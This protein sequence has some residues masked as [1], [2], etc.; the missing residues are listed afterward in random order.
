MNRHF[1][2]GGGG[3]QTDKA[4]ILIL[5]G[6]FAAMLFSAIAFLSIYS[7]S[8]TAANNSKTQI[9]EKEADIK[10]VDVLV[11]IQNIEAGQLLESTMFRLET[12][13]VIGLSP[14]VVKDFEEL[15]GMFSRS[16]IV[17]DQPLVRD[18]ITNVRPTN[19]LTVKIP[20]GYRAVT[21]SVDAKSSV[22]GWARP[23]ARVDLMWASR[24][25]GKPGMTL[26]VQNAQILSAERMI[27]ANVKAGTPLPST[28]T[29]LVTAEDA[30]K[31]QLAQTTGSLSLN[32]RGDGDGGKGASTGSINIDA[33]LGTDNRPAGR[34]PN[35]V[36]VKMRNRKGEIEEWVY[37]EGKLVPSSAQV[38]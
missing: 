30:A 24:I 34:D 18:Y 20:E 22:E 27:D 6:V 2:G 4:R 10:M 33:L 9:V 32:L 36:V 38:P 13:P 16:L 35:A 1:G 19:A 23:G 28:V 3:R 29:L 37:K 7:G 12:R 25:N 21:I 31:V 26:I 11:P 14:R 8:S 15:K 5:A 17:P